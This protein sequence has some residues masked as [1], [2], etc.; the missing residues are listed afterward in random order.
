MNPIIHAA[1]LQ[2]L[3]DF[4][5]RNLY[6]QIFG[7]VDLFYAPYIRLTGKKEIKPANLKD[8]DPKNNKGI[9]LIPQV[10]TNNADDFLLVANKV[11]E[12]GYK[13]INWNLG[14][15]YPMVSKRKMGAGLLPFPEKIEEV[16]EKVISKTDIQISIKLRLG[17]ENPTELFEILPRLDR[18]PIKNITIHPRIGKQLYKGSVDIEAFE[19]CLSLTKH[20]I[21][22]NGDINSP[23]DFAKLK[24]RFPIIN[25]WMLGRGLIATPW[26]PMMIKDNIVNLPENRFELLYQF[27]D[28]LLNEYEQILSGEAH[29]VLKM[30]S[31]WAYWMQ[32]FLD[33]KK[34]YKKIKKAKSLPEYR[35]RV[36]ELFSSRM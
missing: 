13:E 5:F 18:F 9:Y 3:T 25:N 4:R 35:T 7:G 30:K 1:P 11:K 23:E 36:R 10:L 8:I 12:L 27:H 22:Y 17:N 26:L 19:I 28:L 29:I 6:H 33:S 34:E 20:T 21:I 16:L 15:P 14:C 24:A 31:I 2:G 32:N